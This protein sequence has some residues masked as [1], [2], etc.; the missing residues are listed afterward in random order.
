[1]LKIGSNKRCELRDGERSKWTSPW[2]SALKNDIV[3]NALNSDWLEKREAWS[4]PP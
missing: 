3:R 4:L 1:M 2:K